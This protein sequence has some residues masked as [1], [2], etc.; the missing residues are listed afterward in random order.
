MWRAIEVDA[1]GDAL[2]HV[3]CGV[4][5]AQVE[6]V[7]EAPV[8]DMPALATGIRAW[9]RFEGRTPLQAGRPRLSTCDAPFDAA[10]AAPYAVP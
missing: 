5:R 7:P 4:A 10:G 1:L 6:L 2:G 8:R 9:L 3:P